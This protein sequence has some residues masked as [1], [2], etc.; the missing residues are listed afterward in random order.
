MRRTLADLAALPRSLFGRL[1]LILIIGLIV[2]QTIS[3]GLAFYERTESSMGLM[4]RYVG[5]DVASSVAILEHETPEHRAEWLQRLDRRNYRYTL[6]TVA[7]GEAVTSGVARRIAEAIAQALGPAYS[8]RATEL[9]GDH[10]RL[11]LQ[12][13]LRDGS[14]LN[15]EF[16]LKVAPLSPWMVAALCLQLLLLVTVSTLAV[17]WVT[18]PLTRLATAADTL[19]SDFVPRPL[20][21]AGPSEVLRAIRAFNLMQRRIND[22][23]NER[24]QILAAISHDLQTPMTRMRLRAE[25]LED[26]ELR[27]RLQGDLDEMQLLVTDG[28]A[29][30]RDGQGVTESACRLNLDALLDSLVDDYASAGKAVTLS[31]TLDEPLVSRPNALRRI[32]SNLIDNALKFGQFAEVRIERDAVDEAPPHVS[33]LVLDRGPGIPEE[34][35]QAVLQP[36]YRLER[37]RN[38]DTGGSGLGLAITQQL[39]L[40]LGGQLSLENREGGGL[41]TRVRLPRTFDRATGEHPILRTTTASPG[42]RSGYS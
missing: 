37:S 16:M 29:Y 33:I 26:T 34:E 42:I 24:M 10:G 22:H 27:D 14:P 5:K 25:L 8:L 3:F 20:A 30:A 15:L 6:G 12:L 2:A 28:I 4:V 31:G 1:M 40:A 23:L 19:A 32:F 13:Q 38:R 39:T 41:V 11:L 17:R 18:Q 9:H 35:L 21:E 7:P 36:F